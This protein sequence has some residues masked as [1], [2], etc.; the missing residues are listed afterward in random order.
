M[1]RITL[2][3]ALVLVAA[4]CSADAS[5]STTTSTPVTTAGGT[6]PSTAGPTT[7]A[8]T[9]PATNPPGDTVPQPAG[10]TTLG[11]PYFPELGNGGYDVDHYDIDIAVDT[12]TAEIEATTT[13]TATADQTLATFDLDLLGLEVSAVTVDGAAAD[14]IR[15]GAELRVS[16]AGG[17]VE[18]E[19]FT[20]A[21]TYSGRPQPIDLIS[22]GV[23]FGWTQT[24]E[25]IYV[26]AE[27]DGARTWFPSNDHPSDKATFT[28]H[29][30]VAKPFTAVANG[31]LIETTDNGDTRTFVWDLQSRAATYLATLAIGQY[32]R[33]ES[34]GP[35]GVLIRDYLPTSFNGTIPAAFDITA[36]AM[37]FYTEWFGP[38]PFDR[39]GHVVVYDLGGAL[40]TQ[41]IALMGNRA[42]LEQVVVHELSHM[43]WGDSVTPASWQEI[44]LNEGFATFS[45]F[46]WTEHKQG[47]LAMLDDISGRHDALSS[48]GHFAI[49]DPKETQ[50][51]GPAVYWR[52]GMTLHALRVEVGDEA[53]KEIFH[54]YFER[55]TDGNVTTD[56]FIEVAEEVSGMDLTDL[57]DAWLNTVALPDL[58]TP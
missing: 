31:E 36:D 41:T 26:A 28:F 7:S 16:P 33:F 27:P 52:G 24:P 22:A 40:E 38:Y 49:S 4:A 48:I 8:A 32:D 25:G 58:P 29:I 43:W 17:I 19:E 35:D 51:F 10:A 50:L 34:D 30:T 42:L 13:I 12:D 5:T 21:V 3:L 20:V 39:Y 2:L 11:D 56:D 57:F 46:L 18:G 9:T 14:Y 1:H 47:T 55:Y 45:E 6:T 15:E 23:E 54:T 53:L 44:W 37:E